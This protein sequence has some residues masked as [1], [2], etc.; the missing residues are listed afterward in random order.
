MK[1]IREPA[2][3]HSISHPLTV[4]VKEA[5]AMIGI[6][7]TSFYELVAG[8]EI[9]T[10]KIGRRRLVHAESLRRLAAEGYVV[11]PRYVRPEQIDFNL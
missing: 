4:T 8:G 10:V 2:G 6:G 1:S 5:L 7:R 3:T 11:A 9:T